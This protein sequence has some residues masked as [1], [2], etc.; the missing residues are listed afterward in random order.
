MG[1]FEIFIIRALL[2]VFFSILLGRI[3][4]QGRSL[5]WS[6]GLAASMLAIVYAKEYF[7]KRNK[8]S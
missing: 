6:L 5:T 4:F 1:A 8:S 7:R 2:A 3:F